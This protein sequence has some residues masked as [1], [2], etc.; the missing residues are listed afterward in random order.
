MASTDSVPQLHVDDVCTSSSSNLLAVGYVDR[1][2]AEIESHTP[3][4][5]NTYGKIHRH[6]AVPRQLYKEFLRDGVPPQGFVLMQWQT[7]SKAELVPCSDLVLLD[8]SFMS[9]DL[10]RKGARSGT[11]VSTRTRC[12]L[13]SMCD[14]R[15]TK[16]GKAMKCAWLPLPMEEEP[17]LELMTDGGL[18]YDIPASE[19]K[20]VQTFNEGDIIVYKNWVGRIKDCFDEITVRLTDNGVVSIADESKLEPMSG[21]P[22]ERFAIGSLVRTK[23][24]VLRT[25]RWVFGTYSPNTPP[26]GVVVDV[27]TRECQVDWLHHRMERASELPLWSNAPEGFLGTDELESDQVRLY[28][29]SRVPESSREEQQT[30]KSRSDPEFQGGIRVRFKNLPAA[31]VKYDGS[32]THGKLEKLDR[33]QSL[34]YDLNV[35][36]ITSTTTE[37]DVLWSDNTIETVRTTS[38]IPD[39]SIDDEDAVFAG[40]VVCTNET[41]DPPP[42]AM[43]SWAI[44]PTRV[45]IA[46]SVNVKDRIAHVTW[47][48][49]PTLS[50]CDKSLTLLVP[51]TKVGSVGDEQPEE[52]SFYDIR[53][54]KSIN[55]NRGDYVLLLRIP[56]LA[57]T[58]PHGVNWFGEIVDL[59]KNGKCTIRLGAA[60]P[61]QEV[62]CDITDT[63]PAMNLDTD[64]NPFTEDAN[65]TGEFLSEGSED[66]DYDMDD[67]SEL[68]EDVWFEEGQDIPIDE[69]DGSWSTEDEGD[70]FSDAMSTQDDTTATE[71]VPPAAPAAQLSHTAQNA[72]HGVRDQAMANAPVEEIR[73]SSLPNAPVAYEI[74]ETEVPSGHHYLLQTGPTSANHMKGVSK[75]HKILSAPG[76]LPEGV[77]VRTW[78]SRM[79]LIRVL[80]VGPL[81]TP[82]EYAP[83]MID[84]HLPSQYPYEPPKAFFHS[85]TAE[86]AGMSGRVNP[87]LYEEG[88]ICLSLLGTW[89]GDEARNESWTPHQST[90]L[91]VLVSILGLV[92]VREPYYNEAGFE[93]LQGLSA[94]NQNSVAYTERTYLRARA[95]LISP[96]S[97]L[98]RGETAG[99]EGFENVLRWLYT[100]VDGAK[101]LPKAISAAHTI[102]K[103]SEDGTKVET[104]D[105]LSVVSRGAALPLKRVV[106]RLEQLDQEA[107]QSK[108]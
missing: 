2:H 43:T 11:V 24:G 18:L 47:F 57:Q 104:R 27:R 21:D 69:E 68:D 53:A 8:R 33:T 94:I 7:E 86:G 15:E 84:L 25:G 10:V 5:T 70:D 91:Q 98:G 56:H 64:E 72:S 108:E 35:F 55:R 65:G 93:P 22:E 87:N 12:T 32:T 80:F 102:L 103:N 38:I 9:G 51:G 82:Y 39:P 20:L 105:G 66:M 54:P 77:F 73:L 13:L 1:T 92:L 26:I 14:V 67:L 74:L 79:D 59:G 100:D 36:T 52:V 99:L 50:F 63:V 83:F 58:A 101:L 42:E 62:E 4:P 6:K 45:G 107:S 88:K 41:R 89:Q 75:E 17:S 81:G 76:A 34:G 30:T 44:T 3:Y 48:K 16:S 29:V 61:V 71:P 40:E 31:C 60:E 97:R 19:L 78:E 46:E 106:A 90:V 85:W 23:K 96:V 28:D 49:E 95:F 37:A